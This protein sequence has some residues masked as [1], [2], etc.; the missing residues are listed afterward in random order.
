MSAESQTP[1]QL[2]ETAHPHSRLGRLWAEALAAKA[3]LDRAQAIRDQRDTEHRAAKA[4]LAAVAF[5]AEPAEVAALLATV[6]AL[7]KLRPL[8]HAEAQDALTK[9]QAARGAALDS[10]RRVLSAL[11]E[12]ASMESAEVLP[13]G[14]RFKDLLAEARNRARQAGHIESLRAFVDRYTAPQPAQA[15]A[16]GAALRPALVH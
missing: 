14:H 12:V 10:A 8:A 13:D 2:L 9:Q 1:V 7:D 16:E 3:R 5:D 11:A 15:P 6:A 4:A